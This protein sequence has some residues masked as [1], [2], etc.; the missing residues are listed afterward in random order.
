M[1][2]DRKR[3]QRRAGG[4]DL[5]TGAGVD[6]RTPISNRIPPGKD[7]VGSPRR[8]GLADAEHPR[9][10]HV[11]RLVQVNRDRRT[12]IR[13]DAQKRWSL[14]RF[15]HAD[16]DPDGSDT[17]PAAHRI[18]PV[19]RQI[20][21][22]DGT[23]WRTVGGGRG[24]L[25]QFAFITGTVYH[26]NPVVIEVVDRGQVVEGGSCER[27][28]IDLERTVGSGE[29]GGSSVN[30][31]APESCFRRCP[32]SQQNHAARPG[33]SRDAGWALRQ[34]RIQGNDDFDAPGACS[35]PISRDRLKMVFSFSQ[36]QRQTEPAAAVRLHRSAHWEVIVEDQNLGIDI[37]TPRDRYG[38]ELDQLP[39]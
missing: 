19:R 2:L 33:R 37:G 7:R 16:P 14:K 17:H 23:R 34:G 8:S 9:K 13:G 5:Q 15:T 24:Q 29:R 36:S 38:R 30:V 25:R 3:G 6:R 32:P 18:E 31:E 21:D 11:R 35:G 1:R 26:R 4:I 22:S 27:R 20:L 28:A 10:F 39:A 12:M